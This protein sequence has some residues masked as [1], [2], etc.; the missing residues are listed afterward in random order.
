M[1]YYTAIC[2]RCPTKHFIKP[3]TEN[4][5]NPQHEGHGSGDSKERNAKILDANHTPLPLGIRE[6]RAQLWMLAGAL[7]FIREKVPV[8]VYA[9]LETSDQDSYG[10]VLTALRSTP[11]GPDLLPSWD[12]S[13]HPLAGFRDD[14]GDQISDLDWDGVVGEDDGGYVTIN[15]LTNKRGV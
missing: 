3:G 12:D 13:T 14:I 4:D 7:E 11:A 10:F 8:A 6:R 15:V 2:M 1:S 5:S 9:D